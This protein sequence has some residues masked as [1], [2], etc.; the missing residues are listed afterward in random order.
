VLEVAARVLNG[1]RRDRGAERVHERLPSPGLAFPKEARFLPVS[2]ASKRKSL[3]SSSAERSSSTG[4]LRMS[5][6]FISVTPL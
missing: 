4:G 2:R 5:R 1:D 6:A 3:A